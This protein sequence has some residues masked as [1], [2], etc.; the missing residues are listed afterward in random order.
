MSI[1]NRE[2]GIFSGWNKGSKKRPQFEAYYIYVLAF[3]AGYL[4][5]DLGILFVRPGMLP[6]QA[7]PSRP[8]SAPRQ[9]FTSL[10][11]YQKIKDRNVFNKDGKIPPALTADG[12]ESP[13][14]DAPPVASTLPLK[15]EGTLVHMNP[16][17]SVATISSKSKTEAKA[18]MVDN[19]IEGMARV[20]KIERR[21][22]IFRNLSTNHLEYIDIPQDS[23]VTFGVKEPTV[24]SEEVTK[25]GE[26]DFVMTRS[27]INKYTSDLG[28]VLQQAR[29]V[30]NIVPGSGGR[31]DGFRFVA[32]QPGSIFEQLGFKP[33]DVIKSVNGEP[34]NSPTKAMEMYN[35]L[36]SENRFSFGVER[37]GHD[38]NFSYNVNE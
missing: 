17:R 37:N 21:K 2:N 34:V 16:K 15:L 1:F 27:N 9:Q 33:M 3:F 22:V 19:V 30:P 25:K 38:E 35:A 32:I 10:N 26:F 29:M 36:K 6:T 5:S 18:Y 31:V 13:I 8:S 28:S 14:I 11:Q 20:T 12:S 23:A 4:L 7:P 24:G